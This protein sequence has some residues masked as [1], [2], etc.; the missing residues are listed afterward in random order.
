MLVQK[1]K[2]CLDAKEA[3]KEEKNGSR[4]RGIKTSTFFSFP[5]Q[6]LV[7]RR[8]RGR[9]LGLWAVL[10]FLTTPRRRPSRGHRR[11]LEGEEEQQQQGLERRRKSPPTSSSAAAEARSSIN[12]C[13]GCCLACPRRSTRIRLA[14]EASRC[15][16]SPRRWTRPGEPRWTPPRPRSR[17]CVE[18]S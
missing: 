4:E 2:K 5:R 10:R 15:A 1:Q 9:E 11:W 17:R 8:R 12:A 3:K 6:S 18:K 16:A 7:K 14:L 13:G